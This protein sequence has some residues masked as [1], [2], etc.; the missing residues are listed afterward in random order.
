MNGLTTLSHK[1]ASQILNNLCASGYRLAQTM[2]ALE[3]W[4]VHEAAVLAMASASQQQQQQQQTQPTPSQL[5][6]AQATTSSAVPPQQPTVQ[7]TSQ[8]N[9]QNSPV[10]TQL[11]NA[12]DDLARATAVATSTVKSHIVGMLQEFVTQS[13]ST[14]DQEAELQRV[15]DFNQQIITDTTQTMIKIQ[16][17][18]CGASYE[19]FSALMCCFVCQA[20][21]GYPHDADCAM[22]QQQPNAHFQKRQM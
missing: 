14:F 1:L 4:G 20:P 3:Q 18:F 13:L 17:Q 7:T 5:P 21:V 10:A 9:M 19:S 6:Q 8:P 2:S 12:W 16:H 15:R 11:I 22:V